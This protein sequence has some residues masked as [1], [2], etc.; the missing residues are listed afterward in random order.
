VTQERVRLTG[1]ER[2]VSGEVTA[3]TVLPIR[4]DSSVTTGISV[5]AELSAG[6][7]DLFSASIGTEVSAEQT[8]TSSYG[9]NINVDC[10]SG[11]MGVV[12]WYPL[13]TLYQGRFEPSGQYVD[14]YIPDDSVAGTSNFGVNCLG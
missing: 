6:F 8:S 14:F 7:F 4:E 10:K 12:Y 1:T 2:A 9:M 13:F 11:Q 5:S 3:G